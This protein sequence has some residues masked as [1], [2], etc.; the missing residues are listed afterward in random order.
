[1]SR[2][3]PLIAALALA[4][5]P[6]AADDLARSLDAARTAYDAGDLQ[7]ALEELDNAREHIQTARAE[8][9]AAFLP[10]P[11]D[12]WERT[13]NLSPADPIGGIAVSGIYSDEGTT[14]TL[15]LV[16][17]SPLIT[18]FAGM[19]R[20]AGLM[21]QMGQIRV[22]DEKVFID[23]GGELTTVVGDRVL[24]QAGGATPTQMSH[25]LAA[26]DF[27]ALAGFGS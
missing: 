14:F 19:M 26:M 4:A 17:D 10:A 3:A 13:V 21:T 22:I 11:R 20:D 7:A 8:R 18:G 9:L 1:M 24:V 5:G 15:T 16:A 23:N 2:V 12:G 27:D 6:V 25:H